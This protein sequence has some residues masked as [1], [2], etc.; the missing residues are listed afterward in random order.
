[1]PCRSF[2]ALF[3]TR[4]ALVLIIASGED[5]ED[6][7]IFVRYKRNPFFWASTQSNRYYDPTGCRTGIGHEGAVLMLEDFH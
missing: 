6:T 1:M 7:G 4:P 2:G 3:S 5:F